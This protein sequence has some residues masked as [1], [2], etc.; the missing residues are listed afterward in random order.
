MTTHFNRY[1]TTHETQMDKTREAYQLAGVTEPN[2]S[3]RIAE[4][5]DETPTARQVAD[6]LALE[7]L[8][9]QNAELFYKDMLGKIRDAQA[10]DLF[11][12]VFRSRMVEHARQQSAATLD[13]TVAD[14]SPSFTKLVKSMVSAA[15]KLPPHA[16]LSIDANVE[17]DTTTEYKTVRGALALLG[18]YASIYVHNTPGDLPTD[19]NRLLP[20]VDLPDAT[21][22]TVTGLAR[23]TSN[24]HELVGTRAIRALADSARDD[25]DV[26]L[27]RVARGDFHGVTLALASP[28]EVRTRIQAVH[29]AYATRQAEGVVMVMR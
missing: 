15:K 25:L 27:I 14:L 4:L 17:A 9:A 16:P 10:A 28:D 12:D 19:L 6:Q 24:E 11:R 18:Q 1:P 7:A 13:A 29:T 3:L 2:R 22:E 20:I 23:T 26:A 21:V 8:T 5:I